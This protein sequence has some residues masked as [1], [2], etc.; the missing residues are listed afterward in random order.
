[1][2]QCPRDHKPLNEV[3]QD[4][5]HRCGECRGNLVISPKL[6]EVVKQKF[7]EV[8][9]LKSLKKLQCPSCKFKMKVYRFQTRKLEIDACLNCNVFWFDHGEMK[10]INSY[11]SRYHKQ[12]KR[13][14]GTGVKQLQTEEQKFY[15]EYMAHQGF[16]GDY[17]MDKVL[18]QVFLGLPVE[19]NLP[20]FRKPII[21]WGLIA[22]N[23]IIAV[24][25]LK[26]LGKWAYRPLG[27]KPSDPHLHT[28]LASMFLHG[29]FM[30]IFGNLYILNMLGDNVEDL[31][32]RLG[33]LLMY[34]ASGFGGWAA[35][36]MINPEAKQIYIGASGAVAGVMGAYFYL[37]P[38]MKFSF[39]LF[40][41]FSFN[42]TS[43]TIAV[44]YILQQ[45]VIKASGVNVAWEAHLGGFLIGL[46]VAIY[47]KKSK[48]A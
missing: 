3:R 44:L 8:K 4:R 19:H 15:E 12:S 30:H 29:S 21:T 42:L 7:H 41:F 14:I 13:T 39:R 48:L 47:F 9:S 40:Y 31:M 26:F 45:F 6:G 25:S 36:I 17:G 16:E 11:V 37:F 5:Q 43:K 28:A 32:G 2:F 34:L 10:A 46:L 24:M 22:I 38:K 27:F 35:A 23:I 20:P 1:M 33:Y 18:I